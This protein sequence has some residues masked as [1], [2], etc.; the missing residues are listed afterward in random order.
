MP[1]FLNVCKKTDCHIFIIEKLYINYAAQA[2]KYILAIIFALNFSRN[3]YQSMFREYS[4]E[5]RER[6]FRLSFSDQQVSLWIMC[7]CYL[8]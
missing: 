7:G 5:I 8:K 6:E 3:T 4:R 1:L 2:L